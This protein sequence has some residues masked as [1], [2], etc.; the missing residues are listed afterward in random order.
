[1]NISMEFTKH[2]ENKEIVAECIASVFE[3]G[4]HY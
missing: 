2:C 4:A 3:P 1:M